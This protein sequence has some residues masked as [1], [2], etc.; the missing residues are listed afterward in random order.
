MP[1]KLIMDKKIIED[2]GSYEHP[3]QARIKKRVHITSW[4]ALIAF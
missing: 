3:T 1:V 4:M 2:V